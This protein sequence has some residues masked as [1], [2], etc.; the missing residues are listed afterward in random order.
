MI[1]LDYA[2]SAPPYPQ[3]AERVA[4]VMTEFFGNPGAIH[5]PGNQSRRILQESRRTVA[6][7]LGVRE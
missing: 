3:V 7:L 2:A 6:R 4:Q 1:Y 5:G